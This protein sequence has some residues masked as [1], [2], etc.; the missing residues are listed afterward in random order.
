MAI[1]QVV[2]GV[3]LALDEPLVVTSLERAA[4]DGLEVAVPCQQLASVLAPELGGLCDGLLVELLV[5]F[6]G[7]PKQ[8]AVVL[9]RR[10]L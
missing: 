9:I 6:K 2:A 10:R 7:W 3:E 4:V 1:D 8:L 5:F